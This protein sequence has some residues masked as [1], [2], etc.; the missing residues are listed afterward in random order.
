[1]N[2]KGHAM[3]KYSGKNISLNILVV[4]DEKNLALLQKGYLEEAG[5]RVI[6]TEKGEKA[7]QLLEREKIHV[8][9]LDQKLPAM[10]GAEVFARILYEGY[11]VCIVMVT[12]K[13]DCCLANQIVLYGAEDYIVKD[14]ELRFVEALPRIV[15]RC[16]K[17]HEIKKE[18]KRLKKTVSLMQNSLDALMNNTPDYVFVMDRYNH[19]VMAND[20]FIKLTGFNKSELLGHTC[21]SVIHQKD[22][23]IHN[24]PY[25]ETLN[26]G[27]VV[28]KTVYS[29]LFKRDVF[30]TTIP[31]FNDENNIEQIIHIFKPIKTETGNNYGLR[32]KDLE[33]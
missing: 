10:A 16:W 26:T 7:L 18:N 28:T 8:V 20:A 9:L 5:H 27:K 17:Q 25:Q 19:I 31:V 32:R 30:A 14:R 29:S 13:D 24:C 12:G 1:M 4:E 6:L 2:L 23:C 3:K 15:E 21:Y 11:D 33:I 22:K